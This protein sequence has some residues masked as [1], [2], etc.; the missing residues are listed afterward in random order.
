MVRFAASRQL[1]E[2]LFEHEDE[3]V[4][5]KTTGSKGGEE[6]EEEEEEEEVPDEVYEILDDTDWREGGSAEHTEACD[7]LR[8]LFGMPGDC[9][10][11]LWSRAASTHRS[12]GGGGGGGAAEGY[13]ALVAAEHS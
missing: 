12:G 10:R 13:A 6:E 9:R 11:D 8:S 7:R 4:P 3:L 1:S 2:A 5:A